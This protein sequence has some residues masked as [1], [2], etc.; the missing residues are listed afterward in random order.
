MKEEQANDRPEWNNDRTS[1]KRTN[2]ATKMKEKKN[3]F[4]FSV[5]RNY[6][7]YVYKMA[8]VSHLMSAF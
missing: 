8:D 1:Q 6:L 3:S 7:P 2:E 4:F 5:F